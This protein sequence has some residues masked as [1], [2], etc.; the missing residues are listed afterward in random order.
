MAKCVIT[1]VDNPYNPVEEFDSWYQFDV[2]KKY[3][4]CALL[5]R[6]ARTSD[7]LTDEE[8]DREVERAID[9]II[10]YD[11]QNVYLKIRLIE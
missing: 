11:V 7:A 9:E 10:K 1:T 8:N 2:D 5:A 6:I 3:N 4:T